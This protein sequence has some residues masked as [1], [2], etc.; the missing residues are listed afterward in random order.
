MDLVIDGEAIALGR[1]PERE[2][3]SGV[4]RSNGALHGDQEPLAAAR[5]ERHLA[6]AHERPVQTDLELHLDGL[7]R[8]AVDLYER[9]ETR[10][11]E[12]EPAELEGGDPDVRGRRQRNVHD[13]YHQGTARLSSPKSKVTKRSRLAVRSFLGV[14][15]VLVVR[16]V[17]G[18]VPYARRRLERGDASREGKRALGVAFDGTDADRRKRPLGIAA[19]EAAGEEDLGP[20]VVG[21]YGHRDVAREAGEALPDEGLRLF[22]P[23]GALF[24]AR[25]HRRRAVDE[26]HHA[27]QG[28][29]RRR[30]HQ[31]REGERREGDHRR[32]E[33]ERQQPFE[34]PQPRRLLVL[35][36]KR[37]EEE[38]CTD[39]ELLGLPAEEIEDD[40]HRE[41]REPAEE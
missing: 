7:L 9:L 29:G 23:R 4:R 8:R 32:A 1:H 19:V 41:E 10:A 26:Y 40:R 37:L 30:D 31:P 11:L 27:L 33:Q 39:L 5:L 22:E 6:D 2:R 24:V 3:L 25:G 16:A 13:L 35:L 38:Q 21:H 18:G 17:V 20:R 12:R 15:G 36:G 14:L 28:P 34:S